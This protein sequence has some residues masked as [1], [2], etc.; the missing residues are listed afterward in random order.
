M[1]LNILSLIGMTVCGIVEFISTIVW[2]IVSTVFWSGVF[3]TLSG[4][5][6]FILIIWIW[7]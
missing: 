2:K 6:I 7:R 1:L 5:G 4:I 3:L